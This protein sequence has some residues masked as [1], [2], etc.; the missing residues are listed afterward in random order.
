MPLEQNRDCQNIGEISQSVIKYLGC[1]CG[2]FPRGT[3]LETITNAYNRAFSER[4][5]SGYTPLLI[6]IEDYMFF[7][8]GLCSA[9][10]QK[11]VFSAP[12]IDPKKWFVKTKAAHDND[13][14]YDPNEII[15][16]ILGGKTRNDFSGVIDYGINKSRECVLAKIPVKNPWEVFAWFPFGGWNDCPRPEEMLWIGKYWYEK[17]GAVPAVM[18][19]STLEFTARP[20]T[21]KKAAFGL[22]LEHFAF[23]PD[24][25]L[26]NTGTI[27]KLADS[28]TKS[29][30]WHF[31]WD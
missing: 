10:F 23:C 30:V 22:A 5:R 19:G 21:D 28:L 15:G 3:E 13:F 6:A 24:N 7:D 27:G 25:V 20:I 26:Q 2:Y 9:D 29:A 4:E 31:W 16:E 8:G 12:K 1:P 11:E 18:T 17:Y 14:C